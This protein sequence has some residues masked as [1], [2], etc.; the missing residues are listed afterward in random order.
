MDLNGAAYDQLRSAHQRE[1]IVVP[2]ATH[3]FEEK[4]ALQEVAQLTGQWFVR[5]S[6]PLPNVRSRAMLEC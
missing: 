5:I 6:E 2:Q 1:L 4:G 3:L